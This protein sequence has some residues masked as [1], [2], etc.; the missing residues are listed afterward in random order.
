MTLTVFPDE[1]QMIFSKP[2]AGLGIRNG[3]AAEVVRVTH[4]FR[5]TQG[6]PQLRGLPVVSGSNLV[7]R[8]AA[9]GSEPDKQFSR[10]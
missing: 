9:V 5:V 2:S 7:G 10:W 1:S 4:S 3:R 6:V 8:I